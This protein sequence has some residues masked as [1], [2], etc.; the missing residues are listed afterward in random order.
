MKGNMIKAWLS[1]MTSRDLRILK[2]KVDSENRCRQ[3]NNGRRIFPKTIEMLEDL[4]EYPPREV[5]DMYMVSR[6]YTYYLCK[7]Y[8][9]SPIKRAKL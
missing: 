6:Q 4:H 5:A 2:I 8:N 1:S 9:I 3:A 7:K